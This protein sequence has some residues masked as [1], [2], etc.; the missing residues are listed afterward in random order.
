MVQLFQNLIGNALKYRSSQP[1]IHV[2]ARQD[3][4]QWVVSVADN[5]IGLDPAYAKRIFRPFQRLHGEKYPGTGI[6]L[7]TCQK[8]VEGYGGLIWVE[9]EPGQG[10]RFFFTLPIAE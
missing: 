8:V 5:G 10:S 6:G 3:N 1:F 2:S 7:A 9:S 4:G